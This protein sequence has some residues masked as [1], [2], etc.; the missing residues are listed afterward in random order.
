MARRTNF[1]SGTA[2]CSFGRGRS[3]R[4]PQ[5]VHET[6]AQQLPQQ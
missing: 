3:P 2:Q 1:G 6:D 4:F 5:Q